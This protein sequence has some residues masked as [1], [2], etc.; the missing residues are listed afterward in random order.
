MLYP[1]YSSWQLV[2]FHILTFHKKASCISFFLFCWHVLCFD[3]S[4]LSQ[5][6]T[7][8]ALGLCFPW[9]WGRTR[10]LWVFRVAVQFLSEVLL[11]DQGSPLLSNDRNI[12][13]NNKENVGVI[14]SCAT[15]RAVLKISLKIGLG[16]MLGLFKRK[17]P[18]LEKYLLKEKVSGKC[19][20]KR[21]PPEEVKPGHWAVW[22][23]V[24]LCV[25]RGARQAQLI[26]GSSWDRSS[27]GLLELRFCL[28][29]F[30]GGCWEEVNE[31]MNPGFVMELV[32][33]LSLGEASAGRWAA[34][35]K[36]CKT[37]VV[38][39]VRLDEG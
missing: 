25:R 6:K 36:G 34:G 3:L 28:W 17:T 38:V 21:R 29:G 9:C 13:N 37:K 27:P 32:E 22:L 33:P 23:S 31:P 10:S 39:G 14:Q 35:K 30:E 18:R 26:F 5:K 7:S 15:G 8:S 16:L 2:Y 4:V 12:N 19:L 24:C 11:T 1:V 20:S